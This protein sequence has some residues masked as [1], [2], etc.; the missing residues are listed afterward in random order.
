VPDPALEAAVRL[1]DGLL[2]RQRRSQLAREAVQR[3]GAHAVSLGGAGS[4]A[5]GDRTEAPCGKPALV[6]RASAMARCWLAR[7]TL[8]AVKAPQEAQMTPRTSF[9]TDEARR[10]GAEIGIDWETAPFDVEEF[11]MGMDVELEHG[12]RDPATSVT[13]DDPVLT[14]KI[15]LAHLNEFADY[16]SR[17][18]RMEG[19]AKAEHQGA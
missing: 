14:A 11:R 13:G 1:D 2:G 10:V 8:F 19:E 3:G 18:S 6:A 17:L 5:I 15:A 16:Y 4:A 9:T 7:R 12:L